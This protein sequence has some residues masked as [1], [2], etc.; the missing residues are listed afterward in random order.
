MT[1]WLD[2]PLM[3]HPRRNIEVAPIEWKCCGKTYAVDRLG[4][5][6]PRCVLESCENFVLRRGLCLSHYKDARAWREQEGHTWR[7]LERWGISLHIE[8]RYARADIG[9]GVPRVDEGRKPN[10]RKS[11]KSR[12]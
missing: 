6:W 2:D 4:N 7:E 1:P 11:T 10:V 12:K 9:R 5:D 8:P 3:Q